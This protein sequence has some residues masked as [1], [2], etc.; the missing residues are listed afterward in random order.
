L[1]E[2]TGTPWVDQA[3]GD[4]PEFPRLEFLAR[5]SLQYSLYISIHHRHSLTKSDRS[6]R[7][8][9]VPPDSGKFSQSLRRFGELFR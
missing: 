2:I 5:N 4:L 8:R 7:R 9:R 3:I 1:V 6:D